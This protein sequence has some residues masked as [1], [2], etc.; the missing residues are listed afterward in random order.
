MDKSVVI[1]CVCGGRAGWMEME[2]EGI[3]R[4]NG[5]IKIK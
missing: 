5:D 4:I 3:E 1:V 2:E